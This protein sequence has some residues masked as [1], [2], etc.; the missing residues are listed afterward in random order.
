MPLV[1]PSTE[2]GEKRE[3]WTV[4][5][6]WATKHN[7]YSELVGPISQECPSDEVQE[8]QHGNIHITYIH[9]YMNGKRTF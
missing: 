5:E 6:L 8:T 2:C 9:T 7:K 4:L 3:Y 1:S